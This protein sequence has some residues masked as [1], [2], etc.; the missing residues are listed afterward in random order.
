M[1]KTRTV[2]DY[3]GSAWYRYN[4]ESQIYPRITNRITK[5]RKLSYRTPITRNR[6]QDYKSYVYDKESKLTRV[7]R[8]ESE[9]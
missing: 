4:E 2:D 1:Y 8:H 3:Y 5:E 6:Y 9:H 7:T